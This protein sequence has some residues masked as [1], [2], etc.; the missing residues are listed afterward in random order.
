MTGECADP[1]KPATRSASTAP[2]S[3]E[4]SWSGS[5]TSTSRASG[6]IASS[7]RAIIVSDTIDVSSTTTTS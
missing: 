3:T 2:A 1:S 7:R 6:R 5:P 4:A